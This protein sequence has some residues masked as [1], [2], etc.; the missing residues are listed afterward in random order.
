MVIAVHLHTVT[1]SSF[2]RL[3]TFFDGKTIYFENW[4]IFLFSLFV[5]LLLMP[6]NY[7]SC[8]IL[9]KQTTLTLIRQEDPL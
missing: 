8:V 9:R 2:N 4:P 1:T 3:R 5:L 7:R 6:N